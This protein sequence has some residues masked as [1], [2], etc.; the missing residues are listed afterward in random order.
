MVGK[1]EI[2][3]ALFKLL[4]FRLEIQLVRH[5]ARYGA[6]CCKKELMPKFHVLFLQ[7]R[8]SLQRFCTVFADYSAILS[9]FPLKIKR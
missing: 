5:N 7:F 1:Y 2:V 9:Y 3:F 6:Q 8:P 4:F